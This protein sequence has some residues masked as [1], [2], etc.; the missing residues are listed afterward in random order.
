MGWTDT[1]HR[2]IDRLARAP[3]L[4]SA[5]E[6]AYLKRFV[7]NVD[8]NLFHG[9]FDSFAAAAAS[10]PSN[11]PVGYD[12]EGSA[13]LAYLSRIYPTDYAALFWLSNSLA[14]GLRS[15]FDLGGHVG[16]KYYAF[17]RAIDYPCNF[18]WTVCDVPAVVARGR[19][20]ASQR[21]PE[22]GLHFT[23]D[24]RQAS[25]C[26][27]LYASGSLQYLPLTLADLLATLPRRPRRLVVN[28]TPIHPSRSFYTLNSIG[29]AFC[30]Y[31]V[32]SHDEFVDAVVARGYERR[33]E[34]ENV[35]KALRL[36][37]EDGYDVDSYSGFCFDHRG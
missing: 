31:R 21:D 37:F 29:T 9:V 24:Y 26:D 27:V 13:N 33:D 12:N 1:M 32:Q 16:I 23:D 17:R 2:A 7:N 5:G 14:E 10:A 4:R 11:R 18:K 20:L 25:G 35:G 3:G 6:R 19:E 28:L 34:W 22:H 8:A 15:V 36:P 30:A